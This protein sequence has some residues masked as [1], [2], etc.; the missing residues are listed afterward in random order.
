MHSRRNAWQYTASAY[1]RLITNT[2]TR[3]GTPA[4]TTSANPKSTCAS[5]GGWVSGRNTS[6]VPT[7]NSRTAS[8]T[9]VYPPAN[10]YSSRSRCQM[11][12]AV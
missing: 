11:R 8:L 2:A 3:V 7:F 4:R 1:G 10:P 6:F 9:V 5:P 12:W